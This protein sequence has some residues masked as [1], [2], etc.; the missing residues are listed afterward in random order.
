MMRCTEYGLSTNAWYLFLCS[1]LS[2]L[3]LFQGVGNRCDYFIQGNSKHIKRG[4]GTRLL[5]MS[6]VIHLTTVTKIYSRSTPTI[7][8]H[9]TTS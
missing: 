6:S 1:S 3:F 7:I 8:V 5:D 2:E 4:G 9:G